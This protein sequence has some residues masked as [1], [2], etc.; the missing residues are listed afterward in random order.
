MKSLIKFEY[1]KLWNKVGITAVMTLL[2]LTTVYTFAF[3]GVQTG[4]FDKNGKSVS[5]I[6]TYRVLRETSKDLKGVM[7]GKYI[8]KLIKKYNASFEKKYLTS[9]DHNGYAGMGGKTKYD[10]T[11]YLINYAYYGPYMSSG[12]EKLGLDYDFLKSE[13]SFYKKYKEAVYD[14]IVDSR[15]LPQK[16]TEKRSEALKKKVNQVKTPFKIGYVQG[17]FNVLNYYTNLYPVFFFT[18]A[19]ALA[20]TYAKN[21]NSGISEL[22][23]ATRYGR[24]KNMQAR[25]IAGNLFTVTVYL[26]FLAVLFAEHGAI[27]TLDGWNVSAQ[28]FCYW[29]VLNISSGTWLI[30]VFAEGLLGCLVIANMVMMLSIKI[31]RT[32]LTVAAGFIVIYYIVKIG[33]GY[34]LSAWF[35]PL[36]FIS[37]DVFVQYLFIGNFPIS[38]LVIIPVLGMLYILISYSF[39]RGSF[40]KYRMN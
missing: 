25:W 27:A 32:K 26:I 18:L 14:T 29:C 1:R 3:I 24:R 23:L 13:K 21:S 9:P 20:C 36:K 7:N 4:T 16:I 12:N 30:I 10:D 37:D 39:T 40:R 8:R 15:V 6:A 11:N 38:Y 17:L 22:N 5:G 35:S 33:S 34:E 28:E 31:K 19:F 2:I